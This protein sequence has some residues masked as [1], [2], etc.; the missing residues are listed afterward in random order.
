M[1][2]GGR[3]G[4]DWGVPFFDGGG[5]GDLSKKRMCLWWV[6]F[7]NENVKITFDFFLEL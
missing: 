4:G 3:E 6:F 2:E 7:T 1:G 5:G